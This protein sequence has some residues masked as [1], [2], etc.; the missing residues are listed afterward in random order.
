MGLSYKYLAFTLACPL[1]EFP[2]LA[3]ALH[4]GRLGTDERVLKYMK[5]VNDDAIATG[6]S[7]VIT[8][9][10]TVVGSEQARRVLHKSSID[11]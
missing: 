10:R 9:L 7:S 2:S 11:R 4:A 5:Q 6:C 1:W 3:S 8:M